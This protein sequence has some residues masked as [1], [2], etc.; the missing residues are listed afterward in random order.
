MES[1][2]QC[3]A[4]STSPLMH[5]LESVFNNVWTPAKHPDE[6]LPVYVWHFGGGLQVGHTAEM[7]FDGERIARRGIVVVTI[8]Y[9][10][11]FIR[12][13]ADMLGEDADTFLELCGAQSAE[14]EE[15]KRKASVSAIEY[16]IRIAAQ[17][18][19][20]LGDNPPFNR[21]DQRR[22]CGIFLADSRLSF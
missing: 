2:Q 12:L 15:I 11:D 6:K 21:S 7:E 4:L 19:A 5:I 20:D 13:A 22:A 9:R 18:N 16:A 14:I 17:T 1:C 3:F 8:N 10:H